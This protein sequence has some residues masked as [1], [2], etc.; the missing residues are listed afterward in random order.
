M[1]DV[2]SILSTIISNIDKSIYIYSVI[3][4]DG[5]WRIVVNRTLWLSIGDVI[6]INEIDYTITDYVLNASIDL[7]GSE[8]PIIGT[9]NAKT[10][11]FTYGKYS[12][13]NDELNQVQDKESFLPLIWLFEN[14]V[15][16]APTRVDSLIDSRGT[17]RLFL[18]MTTDWQVDREEDEKRTIAPLRQLATV[19]SNEVFTNKNVYRGDFW[20][21]YKEHSKFT[22]GGDGLNTNGN[23]VLGMTL[24]GVELSLYVSIKQD[25]CTFEGATATRPQGAGFDYNFDFNF[26]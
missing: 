17:V 19:I 6:T 4:I 16:Q 20:N 15:R 13:V 10:P 11:Y 9:F 26:E 3:E 18:C 12:R 7:T 23:N 8:I 24:S 22:T 25:L 5:G 1:R 14:N 21:D 2:K